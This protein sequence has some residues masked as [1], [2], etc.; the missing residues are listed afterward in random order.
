MGVTFR[1]GDYVRQVWFGGRTIKDGEAAAIWDSNGVHK[2][3]VGPKRVWLINST[4]RFL[5]RHKAQS[6]Q[7]IGVSHRDGR[8]EHI[9]GPAEL[10]ENPAYHDNVWVEDGY[11]LASSSEC[12]VTFVSNRG[13]EGEERNLVGRERKETNAHTKDVHD[14]SSYIFSENTISKRIIHGPTLFLPKPNEKVYTFSWSSLSPSQNDDG[15]KKFQ[16]LKMFDSISVMSTIPTADGFAFDVNLI[17]S[18]KITSIDKLLENKDPMKEL[19]NGLHFDSQTLGKEFPSETLKTKKESCIAKLTSIN[20]YPS[21]MTGAH[22]CGLNVEY[23]QVKSISLCSTLCKQIEKEQ[24]LAAEVRT[25][26]SNKTHSSEIRDLEFEARLKKIEEEAALKREQIMINDKLDSEHHEFK[27]AALERRLK[28]EKYEAEAM[29]DI[30]KV[31]EDNVL[32]FLSK[33][34]N[35]GVDMT[36]FMTTYGGMRIANKVVN[37]SNVLKM[38]YDVN[39]NFQ[40]S[41][42]NHDI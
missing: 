6:H 27:L 26:I 10:Y 32:E 17:L 18:F 40:K 33:M 31:K 41:G 30:M 42:S 11:R 24:S 1:Y 25:N 36:K 22:K 35:M 2:Q 15:R 8:V 19:Q 5:T 13:N 14:S 39:N 21:L 23:I 29:S 7:F 3:I 37:K 12:I 38:G 9:E 34:K 4:I 28:Y 16:I 20:T